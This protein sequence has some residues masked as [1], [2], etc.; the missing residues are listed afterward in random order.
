MLEWDRPNAGDE[1]EEEKQHLWPT[2]LEGQLEVFLAACHTGGRRSGCAC[3]ELPAADQSPTHSR[4]SSQQA[5]PALTH[6]HA[7]LLPLRVWG[8]GRR[9]R[10]MR[11]AE[12]RQRETKKEGQDPGKRKEKGRRKERLGEGEEEE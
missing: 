12:R 8:D 2:L 11:Q 10:E 1:V 3:H 4:P 9:K 6:L 5:L 7:I